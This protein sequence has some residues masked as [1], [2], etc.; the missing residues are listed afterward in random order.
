[1]AD[2]ASHGNTRRVM[3]KYVVGEL[4]WH[5]FMLKTLEEF[6]WAENDLL[7]IVIEELVSQSKWTRGIGLVGW[8]GVGKSHLLVSLYKERMWRCIFEESQLPMW[9]GFNDLVDIY[10][11]DKAELYSIISRGNLLFVDDL[12]YSGQGEVEKRV[13][14]EIVFR[15]YDTEKILCFSSNILL[16]NLDVDV[17]VKDRLMEMSK[18]VQVFG[19]SKRGGSL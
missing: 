11:E 10:Q 18:I 12:F 19:E 9:A 8:T 14:K 16:D 2:Y 7:R 5:R 13:V 4:G 6:D 17:R 1:M 15:C 3:N